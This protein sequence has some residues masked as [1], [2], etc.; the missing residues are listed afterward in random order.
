MC[1]KQKYIKHINFKLKLS[2]LNKIDIQERKL[3]YS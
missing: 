2:E 1:I 3:K